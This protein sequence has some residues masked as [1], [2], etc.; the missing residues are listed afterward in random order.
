MTDED[1]TAFIGLNLLTSDIRSYL[2][3]NCGMC[4]FRLCVLTSSDESLPLSCFLKELCSNSFSARS[5]FKP[6]ARLQGRLLCKRLGAGINSDLCSTEINFHCLG[7]CTSRIISSGCC[8]S[9]LVTCWLSS[10]VAST[11]APL[12]VRKNSAKVVLVVL[13]PR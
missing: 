2:H 4:S 13:S 5:R 11:A 9:G 10:A 7:P 1:S 6:R 12:C 3:Y 8:S